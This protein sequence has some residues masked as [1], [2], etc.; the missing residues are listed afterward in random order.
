MRESFK[1]AIGLN[2]SIL[3][4]PALGRGVNFRFVCICKT[5]MHGLRRVFI[6]WEGKDIVA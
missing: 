3:L 4:A 2:L 5:K 6:E 1:E